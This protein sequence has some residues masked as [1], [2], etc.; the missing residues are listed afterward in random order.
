VPSCHCGKHSA[1]GVGFNSQ[2]LYLCGQHL[3][4]FYNAR[5]KRCVRVY[6]REVDYGKLAEL[7]LAARV[8]KTLTGFSPYET[9]T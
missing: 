6:K 3:R 4:A 7:D 9:G 1:A 2:P 5:N 8:L